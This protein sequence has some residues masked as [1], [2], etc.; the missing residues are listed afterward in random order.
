MVLTHRSFRASERSLTDLSALRVAVRAAA[1]KELEELRLKEN[2]SGFNKRISESQDKI[3]KLVFDEW[4]DELDAAACKAILSAKDRHSEYL[5]RKALSTPQFVAARHLEDVATYFDI[6]YSE[7]LHKDGFLP[8]LSIARRTSYLFQNSPSSLNERESV[9]ARAIMTVIA[10]FVAVH[11]KNVVSSFHRNQLG[12]A[13]VGTM[14]EAIVELLRENPTLAGEIVDFAVA[15]EVS[16]SDL[17]ADLFLAVRGSASPSLR[18][19][20][21]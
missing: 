11:L 8:C 19:G 7:G 9:E 12:D 17:D 15:R 13:E 21:I 16:M 1:D 5:V 14:P 4:A 3:L 10:H 18:N 2:A 6:F 20:I